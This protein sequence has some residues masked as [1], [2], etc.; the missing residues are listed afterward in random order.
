MNNKITVNP[1]V[2]I[3]I[4]TYNGEKYIRE[5]LESA[6]SQTYRPLELI[7]SDDDSKDKTIPIIKEITKG[8]D[9]P[10]KIYNHIPSGIGANWNNC[11]KHANGKYIKFLFQDD[12]LYPTCIEEMVALAEQDDN[13]GL[14]FSDRTIIGETKR[15]ETWMQYNKNLTGNWENLHEIQ[16]GTEL[17]SQNFF[18][19]K[20]NNKI[21]EPSVVLLRRTCFNE[22]GF[23][24]E[25]LKQSLDYEFWY[26]L[27][28]KYKIGYIK[29]ELAAFR[30]H[31]AQAT[32][33][34]AS[35]DNNLEESLNY[36]KSLKANVFKYLSLRNKIK[37]IFL[38]CK[39]KIMRVIT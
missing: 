6:L 16:P 33:I 38:I 22:I 29:K 24:S 19:N 26:R 37:L 21:G 4:P 9:I 5:A 25:K 17:L 8:W 11:V 27:M 7:V 28:T 10:V 12:I 36:F 35:Q 15:M 31:P 14:I 1:L 23:F 34:N 18:L 2:S 13:I 30:L 39:Y 32:N 3:C 20:P